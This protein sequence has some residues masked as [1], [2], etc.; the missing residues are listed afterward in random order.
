[1]RLDGEFLYLN[2]RTAPLV[3][4]E[5]PAAAKAAL[6]AE[7]ARVEAAGPEIEVASDPADAPTDNLSTPAAPEAELPRPSMSKDDEIALRYLSEISRNWLHSG[8][9]GALLSMTRQFAGTGHPANV[10]IRRMD[11]IIDKA[12]DAG[13]IAE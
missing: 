7:R 3:R 6:A 5:I 8:N 1:M 12:Y 10:Q 9:C 4:C 2:A 13:C 11:A